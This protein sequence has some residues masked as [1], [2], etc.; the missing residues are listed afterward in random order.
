MF[1]SEDLDGP[2]NNNSTMQQRDLPFEDEEE[3]YY[4]KDLPSHACV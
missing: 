3:G 2:S 4:E 1:P